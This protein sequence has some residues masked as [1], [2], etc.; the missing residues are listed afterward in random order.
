[1]LAVKNLFRRKVR[2]ALTALGVGIG[3]AVVVAL[4]SVS[5]GMRGQ[6]RIISVP[7]SLIDLI[8]AQNKALVAAAL[9][10]NAEYDFLIDLM[11]LQRSTSRFDFFD[12]Q[13]GREAWFDRL[14]AYFL[15]NADRIRWPER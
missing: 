14:E 13:E 10:A 12:S 15:E 1:M 5:K 11:R 4:V 2:T 9:A 6:V 8:D 3:V 7:S